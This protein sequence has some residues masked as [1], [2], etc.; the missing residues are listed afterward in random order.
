MLISACMILNHLVLIDF[1]M[2]LLIY[3]MLLLCLLYVQFLSFSVIC[4]LLYAAIW[5][6]K[7]TNKQIWRAN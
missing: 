1:L 6:I 7:Q 5:H 3:C 2:I 4:V